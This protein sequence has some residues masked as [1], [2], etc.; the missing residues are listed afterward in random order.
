MK[1]KICKGLSEG[2]KLIEVARE[3]GI[4][5]IYAKKL[6]AKLVSEGLVKRN[7]PYSV[8]SNYEVVLNEKDSAGISK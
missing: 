6:V 5:Y 2:K 1:K 3:N 8:V 4:S 7:A